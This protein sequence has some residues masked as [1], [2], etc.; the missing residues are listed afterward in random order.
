MMHVGGQ[1]NFFAPLDVS[2]ES[3]IRPK[4]TR[5][6]SPQKALPSPG[7]LSAAGSEKTT[8]VSRSGL[9]RWLR[10][11][12]PLVNRMNEE[13]RAQVRQSPPKERLL[14]FLRRR[15]LFAWV[16]GA[17]MLP[18]AGGAFMM[19]DRL[20]RVFPVAPAP[21][22]ER[23]HHPD[24]W[25]D[26]VKVFASVPQADLSPNFI[27]MRKGGIFTTTLMNALQRSDSLEQAFQRVEQ[28]RYGE[29]FRKHTPV[30]SA[31]GPSIFNKQ[32]S[33]SRVAVLILGGS[34]GDS[35]VDM[36]KDLE[37]D[38]LRI[39]QV[40][41]QQY[42]LTPTQSGQPVQAG[43]ALVLDQPSVPELK[44]ALAS[45]AALA[46]QEVLIYIVGEGAALND[47]SVPAPWMQHEGGKLASFDLNL[48]SSLNEQEFKALIHQAFPGGASEKSTDIAIVADFCGSGALVQ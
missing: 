11:G 5:T 31:E 2:Y 37:A 9:W 42:G 48:S 40:M 34:I 27:L 26:N 13:E 16:L 21:V 28:A 32:E 33:K 47:S 39:Q 19:R 30:Q 7:E 4:A 45:V 41:Q 14:T 18:I 6:V 15:K 29:I 3:Q 20:E 12:M 24:P 38:I 8:T 25:Q 36:Y 17:S 22:M 23:V 10:Q 1:V 46:P 35:G 43:Q 44:Q